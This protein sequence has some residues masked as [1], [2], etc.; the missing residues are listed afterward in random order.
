[1]VENFYGGGDSLLREKTFI[2][3]LVGGVAFVLVAVNLV[4][5]ELV[6]LLLGL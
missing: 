4:N 2:L 6:E 5:L 3:S 1:M